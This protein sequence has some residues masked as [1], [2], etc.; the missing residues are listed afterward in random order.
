MAAPLVV[1][2][3]VMG[4]GGY[5]GQHKTVFLRFGEKYLNSLKYLKKII[6]LRAKNIFKKD[7][8][9][10]SAASRRKKC[11]KS[12]ILPKIWSKMLLNTNYQTST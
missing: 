10:F 7:L 2:T 8:E 6:A 5:Q 12:K 9:I 1:L 11:L 3:A 4:G